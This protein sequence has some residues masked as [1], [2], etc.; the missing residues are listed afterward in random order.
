MRLDF[1]EAEKCKYFEI[2]DICNKTK[3]GQGNDRMAF[4]LAEGRLERIGKGHMSRC[5]LAL[6]V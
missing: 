1:S 6:S 5:N 3:K 4:D 2:S